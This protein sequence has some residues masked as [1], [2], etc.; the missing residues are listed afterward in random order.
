MVKKQMIAFSL[1]SKVVYLML[2]AVLM[3]L[4]YQTFYGH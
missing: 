1:K 2:R 3:Q 4:I